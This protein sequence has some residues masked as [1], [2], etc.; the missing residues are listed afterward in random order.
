[1]E[2]ETTSLKTST[3]TEVKLKSYLTA[4]EKRAVNEVLFKEMKATPNAAGEIEMGEISISVLRL[5]Q[6]EMVKQTLVSVGEK[7]DGLFEEVM[8]MRDADATKIYDK[9]QEIFTEK[10]FLAV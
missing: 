10:D 9:A 4:G 7:T 6:D 3:D 1:M 8:N 2:R 5:Y